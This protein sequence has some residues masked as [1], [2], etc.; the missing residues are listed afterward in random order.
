MMVLTQNR[1]E[2]ASAT[3]QMRQA[4]VEAGRIKQKEEKKKGRKKEKKK[5]EIN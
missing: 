3:V 2:V 1:Q 5:K 4:G